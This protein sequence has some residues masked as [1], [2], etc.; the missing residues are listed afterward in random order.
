MVM[1]LWRDKATYE[2]Y[3]ASEPSSYID[4]HGFSSP[5][6]VDSNSNAAVGFCFVCALLACL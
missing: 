2:G 6:L 1:K 5:D 4:M 3:K